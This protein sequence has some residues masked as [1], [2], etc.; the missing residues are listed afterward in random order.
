M[1]I[2]TIQVF[3]LRPALGWS[4]RFLR[5]NDF[6]SQRAGHPYMRNA[7][8]ALPSETKSAYRGINPTDTDTNSELTRVLLVVERLIHR[9]N[10]FSLENGQ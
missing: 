6:P 8:A 1:L 4:L 7:L 10:G 3:T 9:R 2:Y 5:G